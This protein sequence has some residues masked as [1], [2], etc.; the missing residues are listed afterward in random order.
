[1]HVRRFDHDYGRRHFLKSV[2]AGVFGGGVLMPVWDA[3][4]NTGDPSKAYPDELLSIEGYTKGRIN[5]GD[6]IT[7]DNVDLVKELLEPIK[8]QQIKTMG[9]RLKI[10]PTTRDIMRLSPWEYMEATLKNAGQARFDER[11]NIVTLQGKP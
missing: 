2:A 1:M 8:Y 3:I 4:A 9:R 7:A 5:T 11:G 6:E 10:V